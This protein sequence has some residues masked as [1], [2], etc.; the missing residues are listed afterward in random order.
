MKNYTC[1]TIKYILVIVFCLKT[2]HAVSQR[3]YGFQT[4][5]EVYTDLVNPTLIPSTS[6]DPSLN[7]Y[8]LTEFNS[9][10]F[11]FYGVPFTFGGLKSFAIQPNGNLRVDNDS[12][13]IIIDGA[14]TYL[15]SIDA[16]SAVSY[17]IEGTPGNYIL[18]CQWKNL[19]VRVGQPNNFANLQIWVYQSSSVIEIHYGPRS[20][21]NASGFN[22]TSGPQ[23]GMFYSRD[24]FSVCYEKLWVKG[25][26]T[27]LIIDSAANYSFLAMSGIPDSGTVFRFIPRFT[28]TQISEAMNNE[29]VEV[30]PNPV[31]GIINIKIKENGEC[32]YRI[33]NSIGEIVRSGTASKE[34]FSIDVSGIANGVYEILLGEEFNLVSKKFIKN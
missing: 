10:T 7:M 5:Q 32:K 12:S 20:A 26:P 25:S 21:S 18:K 16:S 28:T 19:K 6:F 29:Q 3:S 15:D 34:S 1:Q 2:S 11:N 9:E 30:F 31:T 24:N 27:N 33:V 13:L 14:F 8:F 4:T 23:V 22:T 17:I